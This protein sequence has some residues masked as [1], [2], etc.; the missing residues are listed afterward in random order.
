MAA[1]SKIITRALGR[2]AAV[3]YDVERL[4]PRIP[5]GPVLVVANHPNVFLDALVI[6]HVAGRPTRPLVV[7]THFENPLT[8]LL[9]EALGGLPVWR[10]QDDSTQMHRNEETFRAASEALRAGDAIQIYPEGRSHSEPA[11]APLRTGAARLALRAEDESGWT[12]GLRIVP[13]VS[14][15]RARRSSAGARWRRW[16]SRSGSRRGARRT[17]RIRSSPRGI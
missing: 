11:L 14:R 4:G 1:A 7:A 8:K 2:A 10:R 12:L 3:F 9:L 16:E 5:A 13:I 6:F 17:R 15:S